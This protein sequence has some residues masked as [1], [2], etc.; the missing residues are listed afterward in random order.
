MDPYLKNVQDLGQSANFFFERKDQRDPVV[1]S[2][3]FNIVGI[4]HTKE[5]FEL[6]KAF[7]EQSIFLEHQ[8]TEIL[9][10]K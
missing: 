10:I 3:L 2:A 8:Q 5:M 4:L 7:P 9:K 6:L 1:F